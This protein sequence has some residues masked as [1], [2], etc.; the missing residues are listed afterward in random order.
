MPLMAAQVWISEF[1][2]RKLHLEL[3]HGGE[4]MTPFIGD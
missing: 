2:G 4:I 3:I 1:P